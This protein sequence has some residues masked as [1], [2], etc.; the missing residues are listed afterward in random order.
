MKTKKIT[1]A[2]IAATLI[3]ASFITAEEMKTDNNII[4]TPFD[5]KWADAPGVAPGAK[6]AVIE[7]NL[8]NAVPF[9]FRRIPILPL[10]A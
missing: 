7:G 3:L 10:S 4:V 2:V 9:T 6:I 5:L 8:K 1:L